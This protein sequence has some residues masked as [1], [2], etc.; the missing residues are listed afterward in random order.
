MST[1]LITQADSAAL[2]GMSNIDVNRTVSQMSA[3]MNAISSGKENI[4]SMTTMLEKQPWYKKMWFTLIGKNKATVAEIQKNKDRLTGY[5]AEALSVLYENN[6]IQQNQVIALGNAINSVNSQLAAT[7]FELLKTQEAFAKFKDEIV[8]TIGNLAGKLNEKITSVDNFHMIID[9]ILLGTYDL[10][11]NLASIFAV[12]S[13]IDKRMAADE[14]KMQILQK[15]LTK[16]GYLTDEELPFLAH[17]NSIA[18]LPEQYVGTLY[19]EFSCLSDNTYAQMFCELIESYSMLPKMEKKSKKLDLI[20]GGIMQK[21]DVEP[22]T[23]FSTNEI[24]DYFIEGKKEY[25]L[26]IS[27]VEIILELPN[28]NSASTEQSAV[29]V[30]NDENTTETDVAEKLSNESTPAIVAESEPKKEETKCV[31]TELTDVNINSILGIG[32]GETKTFSYNT[33]HFNSFVNCQ[34]TLNFNHC[35]IIYNET[36]AGFGITLEGNATLNISDSEIICKGFSRKGFITAQ[37]GNCSIAFMNNTFFDCTNFFIIPKSSD[38]P[39]MELVMKSC[40]LSNCLWNFLAFCAHFSSNK[41]KGK[42]IDCIIRH[43]AIPAYLNGQDL[44]EKSITPSERRISFGGTP[45]PIM[46]FGLEISNTRFI[47]LITDR[48]DMPIT[49]IDTMQGTIENCSFNGCEWYKIRASKLY[50]CSFTNCSALA[51]VDDSF[52]KDNAVENC[53]FTGC[54]DCIRI[55]CYT[56]IRNCQFYNC[57]DNIIDGDSA[58]GGVKIEFC[59]FYNLQMRKGKGFLVNNSCIYLTRTKEND[60]EINTISKCIF[61]G[62]SLNDGFLIESYTGYGKPKGYIIS[63]EECSFRNCTTNSANKE[64]VKLYTSYYGAFNKVYDFLG[65]SCSNCTGLDKVNSEGSTCSNAVIRTT[66]SDGTPIGAT[67]PT[68]LENIG[69]M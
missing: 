2:L 13:Q 35:R 23:A 54:V 56:T 10:D 4:D 57:Y 28:E 52:E 38:R 44:N 18:M 29:S 6:R 9:E 37:S 66:T 22:E 68:E 33:V 63:V 30:T 5:T 26:S 62:C 8:G 42:V 53:V 55:C 32:N 19:Y 51:S 45:D 36:D 48:K 11:N 69:I 46:R 21:Y 25:L 12:I 61:D 65:V 39:N 58:Y 49:W 50:N 59:E 27:D 60:C 67:I 34:G 3:L 17:M 24:Y 20:I 14:R 16:N 40:L 47:N 1:T 15:N 43:D 41:C 31:P 64:I 7:N